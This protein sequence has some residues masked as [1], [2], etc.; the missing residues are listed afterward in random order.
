MMQ[1][2]ISQLLEDLK[3]THKVEES[4]EKVEFLDE[5]ESIEAHFAEIERYLSG[6][7]NQRISD[8]LGLFAE[9]FPPIERLTEV[10]MEEVVKEMKALLLSWRISTDLPENLP[11]AKAYELLVGALDEEVCLVGGGSSFVEFCSYNPLD[12]PL[13]EGCDCKDIDMNAIDE[14]D[15]DCPF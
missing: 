10:Q 7:Y 12:C 14:H 1:L 9:Q 5:N 4:S 3:A 15:N 2:Y 8:V 6:E 13:G 11:V